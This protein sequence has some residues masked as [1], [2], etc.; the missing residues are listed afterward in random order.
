MFP[1]VFPEKKKVCVLDTAGTT[2]FV[3]GDKEQQ[4]AE[5]TAE[6]TSTQANAEQDECEK[7][8][9]AEDA[10]T[11]TE[12]EAAQ[13]KVEG[14][15][16]HQLCS[17]I[18]G[19][20]SILRTGDTDL[21]THITSL[22]SYCKSDYSRPYNVKTKSPLNNKKRKQCSP[23]SK[24]PPRPQKKSRRLQA[25]SSH[26]NLPG[27]T[28]SKTGSSMFVM[29]PMSQ[30]D[31]MIRRRSGQFGL[32]DTRVQKDEA[33]S[34]GSATVRDTD[35]GL[36]VQPLSFKSFQSMKTVSR[37]P[38]QLNKQ[39]MQL[40]VVPIRSKEEIRIKMDGDD[41]RAS[42]KCL[43]KLYQY[44]EVIALE[45]HFK[46]LKECKRFELA[47][48]KR[49]NLRPGNSMNSVFGR[50]YRSNVHL[51]IDFLSGE[52]IY[53]HTL[54]QFKV[55]IPLYAKS[56]CHDSMNTTERKMQRSP[57]CPDIPIQSPL[58]SLQDFGN[59]L[60]NCQ[61][62]IKTIRSGA[63][64]DKQV[65]K[66]CTANRRQVLKKCHLA[67]SRI[68][69]AHLSQVIMCVRVITLFFCKYV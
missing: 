50:D 60:S 18:L 44:V 41:N 4:E 51:E 3:E 23:P 19:F 58:E 31:F 52:M 15:F 42:F 11:T 17:N 66:Q 35:D 34:I 1:L 14:L 65:N 48:P 68:I 22:L 2:G 59:I 30:I 28:S 40:I 43:S 37:V 33:T 25:E 8:A 56:L 69:N 16:V 13:A 47:K 5:A 46:A 24:K 12:A 67:A 21:E 54:Q 38:L 29:V 63:H 62:S 55:S 53:H 49:I 39:K 64:P 32:H 57:S 45:Y 10:V 7:V 9:E 6:A 26:S 20:A 61:E 27:I 36:L